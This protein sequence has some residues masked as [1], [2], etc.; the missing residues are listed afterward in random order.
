MDA[1]AFGAIRK[2]TGRPAPRFAGGNSG[3]AKSPP[4]RRL[5]AGQLHGR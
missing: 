2:K 3:A 5:T 4:R 1:W